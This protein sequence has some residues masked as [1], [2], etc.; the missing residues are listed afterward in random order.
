[1]TRLITHTTG[2]LQ[3]CIIAQVKNNN[4]TTE[5]SVFDLTD[6]TLYLSQFVI[7]TPSDGRDS[8]QR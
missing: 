5:D 2:L 4:I 8:N 6:I 1:M 3:K 7:K